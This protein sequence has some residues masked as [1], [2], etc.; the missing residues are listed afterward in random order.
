MHMPPAYHWHWPATHD[1]DLGPIDQTPREK[2]RVCTVFPFLACCAARSDV[3]WTFFIDT[4][5]QM[6]HGMCSS[7]YTAWD[8]I[9]STR[10]TSAQSTS[11]EECVGSSGFIRFIHDKKGNNSIPNAA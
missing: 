2:N 8:R 4:V 6:L 3:A 10:G 11:Q 7:G 1:S 5:V 9:Y